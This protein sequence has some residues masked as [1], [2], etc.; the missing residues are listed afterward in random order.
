MRSGEPGV[1]AEVRAG[2]DAASGV[3]QSMAETALLNQQE[4]KR[5]DLRN[6]ILQKTSDLTSKGGAAQLPSRNC[7][8]FRFIEVW[9]QWAGVKLDV[10]STS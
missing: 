6:G 1:R 8:W 4:Q 3:G 7:L 5:T 9:N 10:S 2:V